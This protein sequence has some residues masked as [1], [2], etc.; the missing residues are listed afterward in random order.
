[1]HRYVTNAIRQTKVYDGFTR[2]MGLK[3]LVFA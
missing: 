3:Y 2:H 1:M